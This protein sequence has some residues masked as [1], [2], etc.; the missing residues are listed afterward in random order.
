MPTSSPD[1]LTKGVNCTARTPAA[2]STFN[3]GESCNIVVC[4]TSSMITRWRLVSAMP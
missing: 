2:D 3:E 4:V 1:T